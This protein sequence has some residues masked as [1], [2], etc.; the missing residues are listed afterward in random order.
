MEKYVAFASKGMEYM[1]M[2]NDE[3]HNIK[4]GEMFVHEMCV[5]ILIFILNTMLGDAT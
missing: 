3:G 5:Y 2:H 1:Y 4:M